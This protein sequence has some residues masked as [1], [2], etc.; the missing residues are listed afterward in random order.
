VAEAFALV[1]AYA[2][3]IAIEI[4]VDTLDQLRIALGAGADLVLLDNM[5]PATLKEAVA[6]AASHRNATGKDVILEASGGLTL[7]SVAAVGA[8]GVR[9]ISVGALTHSAKVLDIGLDL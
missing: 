7:E 6:I 5:A 3:N 9:Y 1:L 8:T 2:P 4:E